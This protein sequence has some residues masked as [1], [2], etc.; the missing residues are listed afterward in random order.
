MFKG[1][2]SKTVPYIEPIL[3]AMKI[4]IVEFKTVP[5]CVHIVLDHC[6]CYEENDS[7][8]KKRYL[9]QNVKYFQK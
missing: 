8:V 1:F 3:F 9:I 5:G 4:H 6:L 2:N 7:N